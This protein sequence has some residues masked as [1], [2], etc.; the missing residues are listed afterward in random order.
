MQ[1]DV[2]WS[3]S[4]DPPIWRGGPVRGTI[5]RD[6]K[7]GVR[8]VSTEPIPGLQASAPP[9]PDSIPNNSFSYAIQWFA[10]AFIAAVI[11]LLAL[12]KRMR[13]QAGA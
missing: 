7:Y 10:F 5:A 11:Y 8:L 12:R 9:S 4:S 13:E 6:R 2:G 3:L 1:V